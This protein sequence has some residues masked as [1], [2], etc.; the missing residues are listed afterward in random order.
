MNKHEY[1]YKQMFSKL[2][3]VAYGVVVSVFV[4]VVILIVVAFHN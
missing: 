1:E 3:Y 4:V 2:S